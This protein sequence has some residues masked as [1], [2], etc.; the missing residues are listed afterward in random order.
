MLGLGAVSQSPLDTLGT[1]AATV[2]LNN[3]NLTLTLTQHS[4]VFDT[5]NLSNTGLA[6]TL[7]EHSAVFD[8]VKLSNTGLAFT[9]T[10][11]H[12]VFDTVYPLGLNLALTEHSVTIPLVV[13]A[14]HQALTAALH[15]V[16]IP[17]IIVLG[18]QE[19]TFALHPPLFWALVSNGQPGSCSHPLAPVWESIIASAP[20]SWSDIDTATTTQWETIDS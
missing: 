15:S 17:T 1:T 2:A 5:V 19:L 4:A 8:T 6:L 13:I 14:G 10:E 7:T 9:L 11:H 12:A 3:T 18:H 16:T 20:A